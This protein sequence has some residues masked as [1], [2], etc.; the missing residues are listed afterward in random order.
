MGFFKIKMNDL[1]DETFNVVQSISKSKVLYKKL[2][3]QSHPDKH[4]E[5]IALA[6]ELTRL[7]N[8]NRYNYR[9]LL[10]LEKRIKNEL[11]IETHNLI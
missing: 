8:I 5:N 7:I 11:K 4:S 6:T 10:I 2:I 9:E 3:V 1:E